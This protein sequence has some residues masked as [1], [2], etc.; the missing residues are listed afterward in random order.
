MQDGRPKG[1]DAGFAKAWFRQPFPAGA[2][3]NPSL[4]DQLCQALNQL[5]LREA[6]SDIY[7]LLPTTRHHRAFHDATALMEAC[8]AFFQT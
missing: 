6:A 1:R 2:R 4:R 5:T 7:R 3:T 8:R